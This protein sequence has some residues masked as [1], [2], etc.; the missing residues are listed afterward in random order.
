[1]KNSIVIF[2]VFYFWVDATFYWEICSKKWKLFVGA[3]IENLDYF[4]YVEFDGVFHIFRWGTHL[5]MPL[6]LS[7]RL[8][9]RTLRTNLRN[10]T[11]SN[12]DFDFFWLLG[13][14]EQKLA[15]NEK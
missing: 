14:K 11:S 1:M 8:F 13:V 9:V 12:H 10:C 6:F 3:E 7:I 15:Q 2:I 5:Y 4:E